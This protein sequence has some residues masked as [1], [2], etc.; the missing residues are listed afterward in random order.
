[1]IGAF[2]AGFTA[3]AR[4]DGVGL[5]DSRIA[6]SE[7]DRDVELERIKFADS[8]GPLRLAVGDEYRSLGTGLT[9]SLRRVDTLG[10]D[11]AL[12]GGHIEID[13]KGRQ[14]TRINAFAGV[15]NPQNLD[16]LDLQITDTESDFI[17][18]TEIEMERSN[19]TLAPYAM[20]AM[21]D[22]AGPGGEDARW[23]V[24]GLRCVDSRCR[25]NPRRTCCG[26]RRGLALAN[27]TPLAGY[28]SAQYDHSGGTVLWE[29]KAYR[30]WAIGRPEDGVLYHEPPTLEREDQEAPSNENAI[31]ARL[32]SSHFLGRSLSG[33]ANILYYRYAADGTSAARGSAA[34][35]LYAGVDGSAGQVAWSIQAGFRRE[36]NTD[37]D[38]KLDLWHLDTDASGPLTTLFGRTVAA[39]FKWNHR[40]E[41]KQLFNRFSFRS[42]LAV[43]G[44]SLSHVGV[45]SLLYGY[46]T[47]RR[48]G[49]A[50]THYLGAELSGQLPRGG[51]VKL[52]V[53][54]LTGGRVCVSGSCR[55][56]PPF[57]GARLDVLVR[58]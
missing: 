8:F 41:E 16:P 50:P 51:L 36:N 37:G 33:F 21:A 4:V 10:V 47:E 39:T 52:F 11:T 28:A 54:R 19:Y 17:G 5:D 34:A 1:M 48:D 9:L 14:P 25:K 38:F 29:G 31:G 6:A 53:G 46:T 20:I 2:S 40:E 49:T 55:D 15:T 58:Y 42:G 24:G 12:R 13:L 26:T 7:N 30:D 35:H 44:L 3:S 43:A 32:R 22:G 23:V 45:V 27:E 57:D 18:A 56:V